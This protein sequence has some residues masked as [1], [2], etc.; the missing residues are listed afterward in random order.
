MERDAGETTSISSGF[1]SVSNTS[2]FFYMNTARCQSWKVAS[3]SGSRDTILGVLIRH[4]ITKKTPQQFY[5]EGLCNITPQENS[6][7]SLS[8]KNP[9]VPKVLVPPLQVLEAS[10][11]RSKKLSNLALL[12]QKLA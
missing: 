7:I 4:W 11:L 12:N 1:A 3:G 6:S 10:S 5:Q 2:V 8:Q 9:R